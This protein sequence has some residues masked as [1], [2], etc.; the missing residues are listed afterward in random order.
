MFLCLPALNTN[1][2]RSMGHR[3]LAIEIDEEANK[4]PTFQSQGLTADMEP[5]MCWVN[6]SVEPLFD[7]ARS[8]LQK[9][10]TAANNAIAPDADESKLL[11]NEGDVS[12]ATSRYLVYP[13]NQVL[14]QLFP[15]LRGRL[16]CH[17]EKTQ[18]CGRP[19]IMWT[20]QK[21]KRH[22]LQ[23]IAVLELKN[24]VCPEGDGV[25]SRQRSRLG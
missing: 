7:L 24:P 8:A 19:D 9:P 20:Y 21:S 4:N 10:V 22:E 5:P 23:F 25:Q 3:L 1:A 11:Y 14:F 13:V 18:G 16:R 12:R 15:S 2:I 6:A 17:N